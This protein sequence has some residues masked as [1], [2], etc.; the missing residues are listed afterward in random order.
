[1][2]FILYSTFYETIFSFSPMQNGSSILHSA[3]LISLWLCQYVVANARI[4]KSGVDRCASQRTPTVWALAFSLVSESKPVHFAFLFVFFAIHPAANAK[5]AGADL[6][7]G[8]LPPALPRML[9]CCA[10]R[11]TA[12]RPRHMCAVDI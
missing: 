9:K 2:P 6:D 12:V 11:L 4:W 1:M 5:I 3:V 7:S 10:S 8:P